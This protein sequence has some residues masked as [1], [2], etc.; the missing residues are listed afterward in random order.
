MTNAGDFEIPYRFHICRPILMEHVLP[1]DE[2]AL[3][4]LAERDPDMCMK[5][6]QSEVFLQMPI[7]EDDVLR[8]LYVSLRRSPDQRLAMEEFLSAC[9]AKQPV[10]LSLNEMP[11]TYL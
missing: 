9:G 8:A 10:G 1:Q 7:F 2:K 6:F 11:R 4:E 3:G 5:L